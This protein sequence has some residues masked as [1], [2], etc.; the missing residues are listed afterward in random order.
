ME[1]EYSTTEKHQERCKNYNGGKSRLNDCRACDDPTATECRAA[2]ARAAE[3]PIR[4]R[5]QLQCAQCGDD[6]D[7]PRP[8]GCEICAVITCRAC[9]RFDQDAILEL[10]G[11]LPCHE[12]SVHPGSEAAWGE[13]KRLFKRDLAS[14]YAWGLP[15]QSCTRC[16]LAA[17]SMMDERSPLQFLIAKLNASGRS[18]ELNKLRLSPSWPSRYAWWQCDS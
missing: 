12:G 6:R 1:Q 18:P 13:Q 10:C 7:I 11:K 2:V 17:I 5:H 3:E 15:V 16:L 9:R 4:S 8:P 14:I